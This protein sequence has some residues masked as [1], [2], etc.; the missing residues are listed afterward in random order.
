[1]AALWIVLFCRRCFLRDNDS[2]PQPGERDDVGVCFLKLGFRITQAGETILNRLGLDQQFM[3]WD[4]DRR[5]RICPRNQ[6][7]GAHHP[8][9]F[10][11]QCG[12]RKR[13]AAI[14]ASTRSK[15]LVNTSAG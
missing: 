15:M 5:M 11:D 14:S 2:S 6:V 12:A 7:T 9:F 10:L 3:G 8:E 13:L 1:M 4:I